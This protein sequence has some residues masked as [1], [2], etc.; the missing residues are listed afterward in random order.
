MQAFVLNDKKATSCINRVFLGG[1]NEA[2]AASLPARKNGGDCI[3]DDDKRKTISEML[4]NVFL[5]FTFLLYR[6]GMPACLKSFA[7]FHGDAEGG[8]PLRERRAGG[9]FPLALHDNLWPRSPNSKQNF[10]PADMQYR[11]FFPL[12]QHGL[13]LSESSMF[14][15]AET[16][17]VIMLVKRLESRMP[18]PSPLKRRVLGEIG[19]PM[20][21]EGTYV[22][23]GNSGA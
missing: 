13:T 7:V 18:R 23:I 6:Y 4:K 9:F 2:P 19:P 14:S 10:K 21:P 12:L 3:H 16:A 5:F 22:A 11:Q 17:A 1:I 20:F 15:A 8:R